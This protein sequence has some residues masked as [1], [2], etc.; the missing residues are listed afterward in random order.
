[1]EYKDYYKIMGVD[2]NATAKDIKQA[3][4]RLARQYHPDVNPDNKEAENK[5]KEIN[6]AYEVLGDTDKRK[7]YDELGANWQQYEQWQRAGG[8][9][10]GQPFDWSHFGFAAGPGDS[11]RYQ[12]R[13]MTEDDLQDLFGD[14]GPF[15]GFY[16]TFFGEPGSE[17][18]RQYRAR[19]RPRRGQDVEQQV[20]ISLEEAF[21]GTTMVLQ[22]TDP[23]GKGRRIEAKVPAGVQDGSRVRLTG[24]GMP[25]ASGG[26]AGDLFLVV[27]IRPHH[28][29][30]RKGDNLHLKLKV[31]LTTAILG[32]E[33]EV[34]T[35]GSKVMLTIPLET[36]NGKSFRL[37]GKG[38]PKLKS[39]NQYGDLYAEM[40][41]VLPE[42]LS[43]EE[44][45]LFKELADLQ[46]AGV[47]G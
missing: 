19:T 12:Y 14:A 31:P 13:T 29:F 38:M 45:K 43:D 34:P 37:K 7:K 8:Q 28:I 42:Q 9:A 6:E 36:Q 15:S 17:V 26:Q 5:F 27:K 3:Y 39:P 18:N 23:S 10:S 25:G 24:Q 22:M 35:L 2:K 20:E 40:T 33:V 46:A 1:M 47:S 30:D 21:H 11:S 44:R 4:R 32:G 41:V 16:Y